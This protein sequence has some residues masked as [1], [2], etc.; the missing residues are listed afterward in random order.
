MKTSERWL[1]R[2]IGSIGRTVTGPLEYLK[3]GKQVP[4][5]ERNRDLRLIRKIFDA[6]WYRATYGD[7]DKD[8][9]NYYLRE[10]ARQ[11]H[12]PHPL[13][14]PEWYARDN[15]DL[16]QSGRNP[17]AHFLDTGYKQGRN[18]HPV[19]D[20][21]WY[22]ERYTDVR[23]A[24]VNPLVH[25]IRD[26]SREG[27]SP[28]PLFDPRWYGQH[29]PHVPPEKQL[30]HY[31]SGAGH[32]PH[33][34]FDDAFYLR[35]VPGLD[36]IG[37]PP[38]VHYLIRG[39]AQGFDPNPMFDTD[40]YVHN[41]E[42]LGETGENPLAHYV[43]IGAEEGRDP[44]PD[45]DRSWYGYRHPDA[46]RAGQDPLAHYLSAGDGERATIRPP[47]DGVAECAVLD[48]PYE[49]RRAP[50]HLQDRD[51]CV[52]VTYSADGSIGEHTRHY[53][54][55][56]RESGFLIILTVATPGL[57][58]PLPTFCDACEGLIIRRNHGWDFAA[59]ATA[60]SVLPDLW[61]ARCLLLANDS[62]YGPTD[63][64]QF[65]TLVNRVRASAA[66]VVALT[67]SHQVRHHLMSYFIVIKN[68]GLTSPY[69][70]RFWNSVRSLRD[71]QAV[72]DAY[73][74]TPAG[75]LQEAGLTYEILFPTAIRPGRAINATL[76]GWR[77]LLT[78]G[79]PFV[80]VQALRDRLAQT[81][82][83][84]WRQI[85]GTNPA[86][87]EAIENH[88]AQHGGEARAPL[89]RPVPAPR[90]QY[91]RTARLKTFYGAVESTRP[92][93]STDLALEVP[94]HHVPDQADLPDR[95]AVIA[96]IFYPELCDEIRSHLGQIP[97]QVDLF[98]STDTEAKRRKIEAAFSAHQ[99]ALTVRV[100][101][102][103][104]RD[105]APMLVG[106]KDVFESYSIFLHIHSK[107][108]PHD[109]RFAPWRTYLLD[110]L[111][112]SQ[113]IVRSILKLLGRPDVGIVY[114]EHFEPVRNLLNWGGNYDTAKALLARAGLTVSKE[115][116][117]EFPS[118]SF[119][120]GRCDALRGLLN[121]DLDW[122]D[123][124]AESGQI[125][126]TLAHAIER[127]ILFFAEGEGY[128]WVKIGRA[129]RVPPAA[130]IPVQNA[131]D[132]DQDLLRACRTL[133]NN[134][135]PT[136]DKRNLNLELINTLTRRD[137]NSRP[138]LNL[139]IP[140]LSPEFRFGGINT[141]IRIFEEIA[142]ELGG[143][144]DLRI[145]CTTRALDLEAVCT[146]PGWILVAPGA[147]SDF[148][149]VLV[150]LTHQESSELDLRVND[151]FIATAWWTAVTAYDFQ[152]RQLAYY[153]HAPRVIYLVQDHE[154]DFYGWSNQYGLA[155]ATYAF[156][157]RMIALINSEELASFMT[158]RYVLPDA[159]VVR[160]QLNPTIERA[161]SQKPRE[162]I[163]LI[164]GRPGTPRNCFATICDAIGR[165]QQSNPTVA[166]Q[167]QIVSAGED[168]PPDIAGSVQNLSILGKVSLNAYA[169]LLSR[170][171]VGISLMMSPHPSYPPLE[172]A[173]AGIQT[174]TN[175]YPCKNLSERASNII[176][177]ANVT[178][179]DLAS[180]LDEAITKADKNVG[181]II[182][183]E[184]IKQLPCDLPDYTSSVLA[185]RIRQE[186]SE[187]AGALP[188]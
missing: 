157:D 10:G 19:F 136:L 74:I 79:F 39:A 3:H 109:S 179:S 102:N 105:V 78:R 48:I 84:G 158:T 33:P 82:A 8:P 151:V 180:A 47:D 168:Y 49:I 128:R 65:S 131:D 62:L 143:D 25:Y 121:L 111:L 9:A 5:S 107:R 20:V 97:T 167:W 23:A 99:G 149:R 69:L 13:F 159:Y 76:E 175:T 57:A 154:P 31:L 187:K 44:H 83:R 63:P 46:A 34:L 87:V 174:L 52:F 132:L 142:A 125:D 178:P 90:R 70:R 41:H 165:W 60:L 98:I 163:L 4:G 42:T 108:S 27:R 115:L 140:T 14:D 77:E 112:G 116:L 144:F 172:M 38:L 7:V 18:P 122:T 146:L 134:R 114:P 22:L 137:T 67:D 66:D 139:L 184:T 81:D 183:F 36:G 118:S 127:A 80:K 164:Y 16:A 29:N 166:A 101:P 86:L 21:T 72:I 133:L 188:E 150:D 145:L 95:V 28:H 124:P 173:Q 110:T 156:G 148:P 171:S 64:K 161:L 58:K 185:Q 2:R 104:G 162:R 155:Q 54:A 37:M 11:G 61:R 94:F 88:L 1:R 130:L 123:F 50:A 119:Y 35:A 85:L 32:M 75:A 129:D 17:F 45:F 53:I 100:F 73:E 15:A 186:M 147:H 12:T 141:A 181:K 68:A 24:G 103:I 91:R 30:L 43:R 177:I 182:P 92:T 59:W 138:R 71:K 126:G 56:L 169:D 120:W 93:R 106:F 6:D 113:E 26:G 153:K 117:L 89:G 51:V 160:F 152:M 40:W 170:S 96:H 176:S 135:L 55:A